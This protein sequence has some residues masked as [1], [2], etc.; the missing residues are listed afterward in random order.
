MR[1]TEAG[2]SQGVESTGLGQRIANLFVR[3]FGSS[4][5]GLSYGLVGAG[6]LARSEPGNPPASA[7]LQRPVRLKARVAQSFASPPQCR[8]RLLGAEPYSTR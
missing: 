3:A 4:S 6:A 5:L 8:P 2:R 7:Q 1:L